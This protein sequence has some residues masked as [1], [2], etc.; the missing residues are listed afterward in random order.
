MGTGDRVTGQSVLRA[1]YTAAS[2]PV[3]LRSSIH[4][5]ASPEHREGLALW[6]M[7]FCCPSAAHFPLLFSLYFPKA[8]TNKPVSAL[9][10]WQA[11]ALPH[12]RLLRLRGVACVQRALFKGASSK[13]G[14]LLRCGS[15]WA[16]LGALQRAGPHS[17]HGLAEHPLGTCA[18]TLRT[19]PAAEWVFYA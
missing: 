18:A 2:I 17:R 8:F 19:P 9:Q 6:W 12:G 1:P 5:Q 15:S 10:P 11:P 7:Q 14:R 4:P 13:P 3:G 16:S